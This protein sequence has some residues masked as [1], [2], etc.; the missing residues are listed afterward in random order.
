MTDVLL[1]VIKKVVIQ[2]T[3]DRNFGMPKPEGTQGLRAMKLAEQFGG[4]FSFDCRA[5]RRLPGIDAEERVRQKQLLTTCA[6]W[7][8]KVRLSSP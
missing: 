6:K 1:S 4:R 2:A 7:L 3:K 5:H 8:V